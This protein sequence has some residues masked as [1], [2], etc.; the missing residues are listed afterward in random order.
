MVDWQGA[1]LLGERM[2]PALLVCTGGVGDLWQA[3]GGLPHGLL[4]GT[5]GGFQHLL[6][7]RQ[8]NISVPIVVGVFV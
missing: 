4:T 8:S 2:Q 1:D 3:G 7:D 5:V 6:N